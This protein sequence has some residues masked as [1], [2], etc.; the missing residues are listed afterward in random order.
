MSK[1]SRQSCELKR[2]PDLPFDLN[3]ASCGSYFMPL[4]DDGVYQNVAL[5]CF[6]SNDPT[7]RTWDGQNFGK[8]SSL[9]YGYHGFSSPTLGSY[10]GYPFTVGGLIPYVAGIDYP[11]VV[12]VLGCAISAYS[13]FLWRTINKMEIAEISS[14]LRNIKSSIQRYCISLARSRCLSVSFCYLQICHYFNR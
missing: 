14:L 10:Q 3:Y 5:L 4:V 9:A 7:C 13:F 1:I 2:L 11:L 8:L 12:T 6:S